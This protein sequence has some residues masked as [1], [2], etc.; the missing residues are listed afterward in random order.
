MKREAGDNVEQEPLEPIE[1]KEEKPNV[2]NCELMDVVKSEEITDEDFDL[3]RAIQM[4]LGGEDAYQVANDD[5][6]ARLTVEQRKAFGSAA[7]S[8][9]RNYM[10]EY[11][12]MNDEEVSDLVKLNESLNVTQEFK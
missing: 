1:E 6:T 12:G 5:N 9:A 2:E 10:V 3:Q 7:N 4:S 8:L 11:G